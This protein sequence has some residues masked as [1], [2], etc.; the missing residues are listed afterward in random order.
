MTHHTLENLG[1]P[2]PAGLLNS[3]KKLPVTSGKYWQ[4]CFFQVP[5]RSCD[6]GR[7]SSG[8]A[9]ICK[10][11]KEDVYARIGLNDLSIA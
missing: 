2:T 10:T 6:R 8:A 4:T 1:D 5:S 11:H 3:T 9:G 7:T